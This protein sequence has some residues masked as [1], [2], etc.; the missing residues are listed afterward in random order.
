MT[1]RRTESLIVGAV[2]EHDSEVVDQVW[3]ERS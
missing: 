2:F 3:P 1:A